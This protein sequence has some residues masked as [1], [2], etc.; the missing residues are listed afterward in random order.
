MSK[1]NFSDTIGNRTSDLPTCSVVPQTTAP[2]R[3][4]ELINI[5]IEFLSIIKMIY[6]ASEY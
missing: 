5:G 6:E 2:P 4:P 1:K 3:A